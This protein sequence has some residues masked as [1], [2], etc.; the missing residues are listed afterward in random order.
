MI[1]NQN[2]YRMY[3]SEIEVHLWNILYKFQKSTY[4]PVK[5]LLLELF[6]WKM[7]FI[8]WKRVIWM[9]EKMMTWYGKTQNEWSYNGSNVVCPLWQGLILSS[10]IYFQSILAYILDMTW[11]AIVLTL[12]FVNRC[13][14]GNSLYHFSRDFL[15]LITISGVDLPTVV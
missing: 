8:L 2:G 13:L 5:L 11:F 7:V 4:I 10:A 9:G 15:R 14:L 12:D 1:Q 3:V 6:S